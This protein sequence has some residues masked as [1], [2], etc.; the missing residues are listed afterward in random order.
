MAKNTILIVED[1]IIIAKHIESI[2]VDF[3]YTV[4]GRSRTGENGLQ[5]AKDLRPDL[6]L[7]DIRLE[8][9]MD[10]IEA[11]GQ[12]RDQFNI[13]TIFLTAHADRELLQKA[14]L[15]KPFGYLIKPVQK[16]MLKATIEIALHHAQSDV[17]RE[18]AERSLQASEMRW[19]SL[20]ENSED[21]IIELDSN[22]LVSFL[23]HPLPGMTRESMIGQH[24]ISFLQPSSLKGN[25]SYDSADYIARSALP[26]TFEANYTA[27]DKCQYHYEV[28]V[29]PR[30]PESSTEKK[31]PILTLRD[32]TSFHKIS[33]RLLDK[34][35]R[36]HS[37]FHEAV[38]GIVH[39][40]LDDQFIRINQ[41]YC[42][43]MG[44]SEK[45]LLG[46]SFLNI[47]TPE[48]H[49]RQTNGKQQ[50]LE[51]KINSY[52][53]EKQNI[54]KDG[55]TVWV[56]M[57]LSLVRKDND[58]PDFFLAFIEDIT[59][60][61]EFELALEESELKYQDLIETIPQRIYYKTKDLTFITVNRRLAND[62]GLQPIDFKGKTDF[63]FY[64]QDD[65]EAYRTHDLTVLSTGDPMELK[66]SYRYQNKKR[67]MSTIRIPKRNKKGDIE[68]ILGIFTDITNRIK[69]E[70][71]LQKL[72][73]DLRQTQKIQ[74]LGTLAGGIAHDFNNILYPII[75]LSTLG[76]RVNN[77]QSKSYRY[78]SDI[79]KA[80]NR[81]K[82]LVGQILTFSRQRKQEL[83]PGPLQPLIK[84]TLKMLRASL[85]ATI[86]IETDINPVCGDVNADPTHI[87]QI[88]MNLATNAFQAMSGNGGTLSVSLQ[89]SEADPNRQDDKSKATSAG[90]VNLK[91]A[92]TGIGITDE[93][94][95]KIF[96]PYFTTK[97]VERGTGLGLS[98]VMG[99]VRAHDSSISVESA[100]GKGT[101][102]TVSFPAV[103][104]SKTHS[105]QL[106]AEKRLIGSEH[107][108]VVDDEEEIVRFQ[109]EALQYFGYHIT[110]TE[111]SF[112]ALQ[113]VQ[114]NPG[115]FDLVI[116]DMTMPKMS[117]QQLA[118]ELLRIR[119]ELP[120]IMC[121]GYSTEIN[122]TEAFT[123]GIRKYLAKPL[124]QDE[125]AA[126]IRNVLDG[127]VQYATKSN[128]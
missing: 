117:G 5:L 54:R 58:A 88:V 11:A 42:E 119:P 65:A 48:F 74:A 2:L 76:T 120:I 89:P 59:Q 17:M 72:E 87:H 35:R 99:I 123:T 12:I 81:A 104:H 7:M 92:D 36:L 100:P 37:T 109:I 126:A 1:E 90:F 20:T 75:G 13:P 128:C 43:I 39:L 22:H 52:A 69:S 8:G 107:I 108:L 26:E 78:F 83:K 95:E 96:D 10:G 62:F 98:V 47:S 68:G 27:P 103:T 32:L 67:I 97:E 77:E 112:E 38:V 127:D 124:D 84:E 114:A 115:R 29:V 94:I 46:T 61:K 122:K 71:A 19:R 53:T 116:T 24:L 9:R 93:I 63:D 86:G 106:K 113:M 118:I 44:Y 110:G 41:R 30:P 91:V 23:N 80:A 21:V 64:H 101:S 105:P 102:F 45:E 40:N 6:I 3:G 56:N 18:E 28:R 73:R 121:T 57:T 16:Q 85:P 70:E 82:E 33:Q 49:T 125:L 14:K 60:R 15:T 25:S 66:E 55:Q 79:H 50:L 4:C 51:G 111:S 34:K 31:G